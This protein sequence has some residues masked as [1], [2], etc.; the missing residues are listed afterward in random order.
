[1]VAVDRREVVDFVQRWQGQGYEK[2]DTHKFWL[3]LLDAI[4]YAHTTEVKFEHH[5][6][7]GG[8][9]DVWLR[10]AGVLIEQKSLGIDLDKPEPR[11]GQLKTPLAQALDYVEDLPRP[12]QPR[13]VVTCNFE[14]FRVYDR[15]AYSKTDL[16]ANT[17]EFS[18]TELA[19]HPEYMAFIVDPAN[20]R[21]EKEREVS[22]QAGELI[23]RLYSALRSG[24]IEPDSAESMHALNVL[25]VRLVFCLYCEDADLFHKD[26]FHDYL[27]DVPPA[28]IRPQ[29]KRL[30]AAL[31]TPVDQRDQYDVD[32][33]AFPYVNGGLFREDTQIPNFTQEMK[34]Y[35]LAEVSAPVDWS[36]ISPT[37]FGGIFEST[38][39]P[40][41]RRSGGMHY[42][43]PQNIHKVIDP[44]FL[45]ELHTEF[46]GIM[47]APGQTPR[48]MKAALKHFHQKIC[49]L[50]FLKPKTSDLI[51][52]TVSTCPLPTRGFLAS[53][54]NRR[55]QYAA[56]G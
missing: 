37:I 1:M 31:N 55:P 32:L 54:A 3:Q 28:Q 24:Y 46:A 17:F 51:R 11:Q 15:D 34:D 19:S 13:Y 56:S 12:E 44:L 39:N 52:P 26:A 43:S 9:I 6:P 45:D 29:L 27:H 2:G 35:L 7:N 5:L 20:S 48:A 23:G 21:L 41:T 53:R 25:C 30:F 36:Q 4:G 10:D 40:Q 18:L 42:T 8:F 50:N 38:L 16:A 33:L 47:S 14:S 22:I 49:S